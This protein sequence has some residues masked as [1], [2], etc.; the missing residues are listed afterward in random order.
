MGL[1]WHVSRATYR[2]QKD[3]ER[4]VQIDSALTL[5]KYVNTKFNL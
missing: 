2:V 1:Q 3:L 5:L 4:I